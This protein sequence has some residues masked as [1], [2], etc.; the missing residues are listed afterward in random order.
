MN[1]TLPTHVG[2]GHQWMESTS[3]GH[4][5][6]YFSQ[7]EPLV[8]TSV[9]TL[10]SLVA[11]TSRCGEGISLGIL[12]S[13][14]ILGSSIFGVFCILIGCPHILVVGSSE[15]ANSVHCH[16][17]VWVS[18]LEELASRYRWIGRV[19]GI[20]QQV[21]HAA[22]STKVFSVWSY[23][24]GSERASGATDAT[25]CCRCRKELKRGNPAAGSLQLAS[26]PASVGSL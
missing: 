13:Q 2:V 17:Y 21:Q 10:H 12:L 18:V 15:R 11:S 16:Q 6:S 7:W 8:A 3:R 19:W 5:Q 1:N 24:L 25:S 26:P 23:R 14:F 9:G 22:S 4:F 20:S